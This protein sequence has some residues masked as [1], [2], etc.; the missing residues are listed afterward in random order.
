[1]IS[2]WGIGYFVEYKF[3]KIYK[4][5]G[6]LFVIVKLMRV[7]CLSL[8]KNM[9]LFISK[10][11]ILFNFSLCFYIDVEDIYNGFYYCVFY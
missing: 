11:F 4:Y 7:V 2:M 3:N 9:N 1:M 10:D 6:W 8:R 5:I